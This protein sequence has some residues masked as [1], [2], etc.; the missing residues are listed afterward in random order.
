MTELLE[1][2][3]ALGF[4]ITPQRRLIL[5]VLQESNRHLSAEEIAELVREIQPSVSVATIYRNLNLLVEIHLVSKL[6][7]HD[8]PARYELNRGHDH[9]MVCLDCGT[10]IK[11]GA[12]P[13]QEDIK[14]IIQEKGFEVSSHHFEITGYCKQCQL[15]R[16]IEEDKQKSSR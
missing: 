13:M 11:I 16:R 4:K 5:E 12:C 3:S 7:L 10:A 1:R 8:G 9:H 15:K 14:N 6:D 2:L